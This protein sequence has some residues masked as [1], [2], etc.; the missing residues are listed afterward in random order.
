MTAKN[1][2]SQTTRMAVGGSWS[3]AVTGRQ[4]PAAARDCPGRFSRY[5]R[6]SQLSLRSRCGTRLSTTRPPHSKVNLPSSIPSRPFGLRR[7]FDRSPS[8]SANHLAVSLAPEVA[9]QIREGGRSLAHSQA[10]GKLYYVASRTRADGTTEH[11][12]ERHL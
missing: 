12:V 1:S 3:E 2:F 9:N 11:F 6:R 4:S 5:G 8:G 7:R 10:G